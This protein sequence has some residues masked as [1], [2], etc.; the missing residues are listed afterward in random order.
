MQRRGSVPLFWSQDPSNRG[1]VG[2]PPI[3][4][5][6]VEPH[7]LTTA[8]HFRF[9]FNKFKNLNFFR[10]LRRKY[11]HP[12]IVMNLVKKSE[13]RHNENILHDEF[14]KVFLNVFFFKFCNF[15]KIRL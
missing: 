6:L 1:V 4:V 9:Y 12:I 5:D 3:Y 13:K 7:G 15:F 11:G 8:A 14:L 10:E 2:K